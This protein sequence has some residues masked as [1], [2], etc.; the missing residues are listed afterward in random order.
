MSSAFTMTIPPSNVRFNG[1]RD[2]YRSHHMVT[3]ENDSAAPIPHNIDILMF[4][5]F[6]NRREQ[7]F[8][9]AC[10]ADTKITVPTSYVY[11]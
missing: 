7:G 2:V 1:G 10:P 6:G 3:L 4:D 11:V 5:N 9:G 8:Q